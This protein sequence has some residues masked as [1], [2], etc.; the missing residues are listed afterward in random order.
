MDQR[1]VFDTIPEEFDRWRPRYCEAL[2]SDLIEYSG[3]G[4]GKSALELG[5]GTGQATDPILNT[6][7]DYHA[8]ELG[9][10]L[11]RFMLEKYGSYPNFHIINDD[12]ETYDFGDMRFDLFYSAAA[13]QWVDE[14]I[15]FPKAFSLLKSGGTL[16]MMLI[17]SDFRTPN[18][19]LYQSIQAVY[20]EFF[21]TDMPYTRKLVY[22][23]A[24]LY[25]F[26]GL[27]RREYKSER[28][29][30]AEEF[31]SLTATHCDHIT[32]REPYRS[33]FFGGIKK[34]VRDAGNTIKLL[35]TSVLYLCRKP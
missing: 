9:E 27:E 34:A 13:M 5:P 24:A 1:K 20:D 21:K 31:A 29:L 17:R 35:D 7:C 8:I 12:F 28:V 25:G 11:A 23:N 26:V 32:L 15:G 18:E 30:T 3:I 10:N 14:E 22:E 33:R 6:R 16:A 19:A 4:A 2:F